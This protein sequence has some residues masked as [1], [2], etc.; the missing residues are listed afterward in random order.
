[1]D[2]EGMTDEISPSLSYDDM[3]KKEKFTKIYP[4]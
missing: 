3:I 4:V 1:M 2:K